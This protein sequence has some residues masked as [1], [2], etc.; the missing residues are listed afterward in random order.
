M[1][2]ISIHPYFLTGNDEKTNSEILPISFPE[3]WPY[4]YTCGC[5]LVFLVVSVSTCTQISLSELSFSC[6]FFEPEV[7]VLF[8][9][10]D[11]FVCLK[12]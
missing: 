10:I 9:I 1:L 6:V 5:E 7:D 12:K 4:S 11:T 3:T 2:Y 8:S